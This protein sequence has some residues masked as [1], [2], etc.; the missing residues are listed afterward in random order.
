M[1]TDPANAMRKLAGNGLRM[2][3]AAVLAELSRRGRADSVELADA[4]LGGHTGAT[5]QIVRFV[6]KALE[7]DDGRVAKI[8]RQWSVVGGDAGPDGH[9]P[10]NGPRQP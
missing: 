3:K 1:P 10:R 6:L 4:L 5:Q 8:G 2:L 9:P 7:E